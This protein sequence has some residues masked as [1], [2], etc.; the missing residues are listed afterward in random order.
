M[1]SFLQLIPLIGQASSAIAT[2]LGTPLAGN[3]LSKAGEIAGRIFGT[4]D[5]GQIQL[6][7]EQD[8]SKL[9]RFRIELEEATKQEQQYY[10]DIQSAR[11]QTVE[12]AKSGSLISWGAPLVSA[13]VTLGFFA[14]LF[15][16]MRFQLDMNEF[17]K[18]ILLILI[19]ALGAGFQQTLNY[20]LGSS[21][22]SKDK[23]VILASMATSAMRDT[24]PAS[25]AG[26][27]KMFR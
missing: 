26:N 14:V 25:V 21:R 20:W 2:M 16:F 8:K 12:L 13:L 1:L 17:Q 7:I 24:V 23:D 19:G 3:I 6:Q 22:Q 27:G 10:A 15:V 11:Q 4:T 18:N 9:E 5:A